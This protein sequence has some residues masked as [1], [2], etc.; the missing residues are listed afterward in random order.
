MSMKRDMEFHEVSGELPVEFEDLLRYCR[1]LKF[2]DRP[3]YGYIKKMFDTVYFRANFYDSVY[4]W[5]QLSVCKVF[6]PIIG[7]ERRLESLP[8]AVSFGNTVPQFRVYEPKEE[9]RR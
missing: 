6:C 3:D 5:K 8:T 1:A 7:L 2:T 9:V 4:D